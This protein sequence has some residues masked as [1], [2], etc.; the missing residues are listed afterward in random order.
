MTPQRLKALWR[1]RWN[2]PGTLAVEDGYLNGSVD[3]W[4][5]RISSSRAW[6]LPGLSVVAAVLFIGLTILLTR[7]HFPVVDQWWFSG[8]ILVVSLFIR[9]YQIPLVTF[10]LM[11][12]ATISTSRYLYWRFD[13]TLGPEFSIVFF[14][15]LGL[16]AIEIY[17]TI[18]VAFG[19]MK[20]LWP[21]KHAPVKLP[22]D[23]D[24][25]PTVGIYLLAA[26]HS[27]DEIER[28]LAA[29]QTT[30]WPHGKLQ[31]T[32]LDQ[33]VRAEVQASLAATDIQYLAFPDEPHAAVTLV[34][35]ALAQST[36]ELAVILT[37]GQ[38]PEGDFLAERVGWFLKDPDLGML[39]T[40]RHFFV[41]TPPARSLRQLA[42]DDDEME[43]L[44]ARVPHCLTATDMP[45]ASTAN[46]ANLRLKLESAG[47]LTAVL[48]QQRSSQWCLYNPL[49]R[50]ASRWKLWVEH[51]HDILGVYK[52]LMSFALLAMPLP[53]LLV[54]VA[55]MKATLFEWIAYALPHLAQAYLLHDRVQ[56]TRRLPLWLEIREAL[57][58]V[59]L[60][61]LTFFSVIWTEF[62]E[63]KSS[64][65]MPEIDMEAIAFRLT[66]ADHGVTV[67][68]S[69]AIT[70]GLLHLL[71]GR[72]TDINTLIFFLAW[73]IVIILLQ[74]AKFAV[75]RE[76][77]QVALQKH[78]LKRIP[79]M[80][81][82]PNN[83]TVACQTSNFPASELVLSV[84][85]DL[86]LAVG[87]DLKVSLLQ[88]TEEFAF[89]ATVCAI[90]A[91]TL[92]IK[93]DAVW[94]D[95]Y[96]KFSGAVLARPS[97][98][99]GW[100][101][102]QHVDRFTPHWLVTALSWLLDL[103]AHLIHRFDRKPVVTTAKNANMKWKS[104]A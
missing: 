100:L 38:T 84:A 29:L 14:L 40:S 86:R 50:G 13:A 68:H 93:V 8:F 77:R 91:E 69:L 79:A 75:F 16:W 81:R 11:C 60:L 45:D 27:A 25:W 92:T 99:P 20:T 47:Y 83:R 71:Q 23:S 96:A 3:A 34:N 73:S 7:V 19:L 22:D 59:Y 28:S 82:L 63:R 90:T 9:R 57:L 56:S 48:I 103:F 67:L 72:V 46:G 6:A 18:W 54:G 58:S 43:V 80:I 55:P 94:Q 33:F 32:V 41:P 26:G 78:L 87:Q 12:F 2:K 65:A 21:A 66:P 85:K 64:A 74:A 5:E 31:L 1:E 88:Q 61:V 51:A 49:D 70:M 104:K 35:Q 15:A 36:V 101:P 62:K 17:G 44:I 53:Y 24:N 97:N 42:I 98:W 76:V 37:A 30:Q 10:M 89:T 4:G 102:G 95:Q 39:F 52:P